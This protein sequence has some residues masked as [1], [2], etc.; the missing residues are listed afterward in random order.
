MGDWVIFLQ[1]ECNVIVIVIG[2]NGL[3]YYFFYVLVVVFVL[4]VEEISI[5]I[6]FGRKFDVNI[7]SVVKIVFSWIEQLVV[8]V[9]L[10]IGQV[11]SGGFVFFIEFVRRIIVV[12]VY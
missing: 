6:F 1:V 9:K 5:I 4:V 10:N 3:V 8:Y 7:D 11:V 12:F 2:L